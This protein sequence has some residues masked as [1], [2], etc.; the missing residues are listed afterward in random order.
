MTIEI[1]DSLPIS[2]VTIKQLP[3]DWF[4]AGSC[5]VCK[6]M[7]D[8]WVSSAKTCVMKVPSAIIEGEHNF[9]I[10][11]LHKSFDQIKLKSSVPFRFDSRI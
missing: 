1:P 2:E 10:N 3:D 9:L 8:R 11:P 4:K 5:Q 7:G 6:V